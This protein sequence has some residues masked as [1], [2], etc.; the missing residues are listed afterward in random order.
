MK[1]PKFL[2]K[3][4]KPKE[5]KPKKEKTKKV[6]APKKINLRKYIKYAVCG[7]LVFSV[8]GTI[9]TYTVD[10]SSKPVAMVAQKEKEEN[11]ATTIGAGNFATNFLKEYFTWNTEDTQE[12]VKRLQPFLRGGM[13]EHA[14]MR[15]DSVTGTAFPVSY[16]IWKVEETSKNTAD[17]TFRISYKTK[18]TIQKEVKNKNIK[19][20]KVDGPF[21]R[22]VKVPVITDGKAFSINGN[23][24]FTNK[25]SAAGL[26]PI[27]DSKYSESNPETEAKINKFLHTFFK[28]YTT[29]TAAELEYLTTD[30]SIQ[31]LGGT[32]IFE[33][34]EELKTLENKKNST[35]VEVKAVFT[36]RNSKVQINQTYKLEVSES[37]GQWKVIKFN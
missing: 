16:E 1:I 6:W 30:K 24:T 28:Q 3:M 11:F 4:K 5:P 27:K 15:F 23:P 9:R 12:R 17:F 20:E 22:W 32:V 36:D 19:E 21:E 10:N 8:I 2:E 25:P 37:K 33:S 7:W 18:T 29:G 13:D 35:I 26:E 34:I 14:G 31:P